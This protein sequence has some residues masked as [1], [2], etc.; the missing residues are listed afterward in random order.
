MVVKHTADGRQQRK[1]GRVATHRRDT[2]GDI[3]VVDRESDQSFPASD[4]PS[5]TPVMR[6]GK[7]K[8]K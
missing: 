7:P 6:A 1:K 8:N 4:A 3:D 5:W 2:A